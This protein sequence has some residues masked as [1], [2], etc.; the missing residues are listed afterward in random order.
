[1]GASSREVLSPTPPME[2]LST[3]GVVQS[4]K[5]RLAP[6]RSMASVS[7]ASSPGSSPRQTTAIARALIW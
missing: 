3:R 7:A 1:M 5:S 6:E 2:C 4:P